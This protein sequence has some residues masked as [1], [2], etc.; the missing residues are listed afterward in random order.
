MLLQESIIFT[1]NLKSEMNFSVSE[2]F[3]KQV[4]TK[5]NEFW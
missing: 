3:D 1:K 4:T 5:V 2:K